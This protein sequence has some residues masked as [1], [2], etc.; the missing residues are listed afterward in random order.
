VADQ[1]LLAAVAVEKEALGQLVAAQQVEQGEQG[2]RLQSLALRLVTL[3]VAVV[4]D[5]VL[6]EQQQV[7]EATGVKDQLRLLQ[8]QLIQAEAVAAVEIQLQAAKQAAQAL[9]LFDI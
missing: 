3:A 6:V 4:A 2:Q 1:I 5:S 7:V 8:G 9:L